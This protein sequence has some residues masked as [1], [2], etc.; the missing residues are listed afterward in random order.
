MYL[1]SYKPIAC[2]VLTD[3]TI[4]AGNPGQYS[5]SAIGPGPAHLWTRCN[6]V[7]TTALD[8][9]HA[10]NACHHKQQQ[11]QLYP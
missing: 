5:F 7:Q 11:Q 3:M 1:E 2:V 10:A 4:A 9:Q 8:G 6:A